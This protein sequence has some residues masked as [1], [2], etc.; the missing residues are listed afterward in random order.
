MHSTLRHSP[1][2]SRVIAK[3]EH[4]KSEL[5]EFMDALNADELLRFQCM[6]QLG[7]AHD[8]AETTGDKK[9]FSIDLTLLRKFVKD[10][11]KKLACFICQHCLKL[12]MLGES[13]ADLHQFSKDKS[14]IKG[15]KAVLEYL[16]NLIT[17]ARIPFTKTLGGLGLVYCR[18]KFECFDQTNVL[19]CQDTTIK[20]NLKVQKLDEALVKRP[21]WIDIMA[22]RLKLTTKNYDKDLEEI[23]SYVK[24]SKD[25]GIVTSGLNYASNE[26]IDYWIDRCQP[27]SAVEDNGFKATEK[28]ALTRLSKGLASILHR[29][30]HER[31]LGKNKPSSISPTHSGDSTKTTKKATKKIDFNGE[32][33]RLTGKAISPQPALIAEKDPEKKSKMMLR[34]LLGDTSNAANTNPKTWHHGLNR[35]TASPTFTH[36]SF[37][38]NVSNSAQQKCSRP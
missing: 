8:I 6:L 16:D 18:G 24:A 35:A 31:R 34:V 3:Q 25:K 10:Y 20:W 13:V 17:A 33:E 15:S 38:L 5:Q 27:K 14:V 11:G 12:F 30:S 23:R 32:V 7:K 26:E 22:Q 19:W 9:N 36:I 28:H 4:K 2:S 37:W 21:H 1:D 29:D